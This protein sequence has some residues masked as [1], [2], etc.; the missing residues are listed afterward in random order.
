MRDAEVAAAHNLAADR[1]GL[2]P[3]APGVEEGAMEG[4]HALGRELAARCLVAGASAGGRGPG[5]GV[6]GR[7][8]PEDVHV[9]VQRDAR[10]GGC[11]HARAHCLR[12]L[13]AE[14]RKAHADEVPAKVAE[15]AQGVAVGPHAD[16]V[17]E[18]G[19]RGPE[20]EA[21]GH[22]QGVPREGVIED[23]PDLGEAR[24]VH[25]HEAVHELHAGLPASPD[26]LPGLRGVARD[27][28]LHQ[29]VL[30]R[31][32]HLQ[33][34]L[35]VRGGGQRH[36]DHV[37]GGVRQQGVIA[38]QPGHRLGQQ[39]LLAVLLAL[40]QVPG[41][42]RRQL[43]IARAQDRSGVLPADEAAAQ[44]ADARLPLHGHGRSGVRA[45]ARGRARSGPRA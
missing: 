23:G 20:G 15:A 4:H 27:G 1:D 45:A 2:I 25:E 31:R 33:D 12:P 14:G 40:G 9:R 19:R 3:L 28:L 36:V 44:H 7:G 41:C 16:V 8:R 35:Q 24:V 5:R 32:R 26:H 21:G 17:A 22:A 6:G 42:H 13:P 39:Q 11:A 38:A 43:R 10:G 18:V 30:A 29:H 34:P 37:D